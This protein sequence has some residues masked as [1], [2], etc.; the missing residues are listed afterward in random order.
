MRNQI[1]VYRWCAPATNRSSA[2]S[3]HDTGRY[4]CMC[5]LKT[6]RIAGAH[7]QQF[8]AMQN[9]IH[10]PTAQSRQPVMGTLTI[11][12]AW[13]HANKKIT[14]HV[15]GRHKARQHQAAQTI[16]HAIISAVLKLSQLQNHP[17]NVQGVCCNH[18]LPVRGPPGDGS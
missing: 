12:A 16:H 7:W 4:C 2:K 6:Q 17:S 3:S 18:D 5:N 9:Q 10:I 11:R 13:L 15:P 8:K 1:T 14:S